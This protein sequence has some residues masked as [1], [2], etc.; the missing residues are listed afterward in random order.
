MA[1]KKNIVKLTFTY[2]DVPNWD[3]LM[4]RADIN[5]KLLIKQLRAKGIRNRNIVI[6]YSKEIQDY[7]VFAI[8]TAPEPL[9]YIS[10]KPK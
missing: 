7:T 3:V 10:I 1:G 5:E 2:F 4:D 8:N 9:G 6:G